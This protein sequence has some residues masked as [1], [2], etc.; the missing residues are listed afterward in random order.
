MFPSFTVFGI[1]IHCFGLI[2][3]TGL[4]IASFIMCYRIRKAGYDYN[5]T[6][7]FI[8]SLSG[9]MMVGGSILNA[10]VH[11]R[12][13]LGAQDFST[14]LNAVKS[15]CNGIVFYGGLFG[16]IIAGLIY[17]K[18][19]KLPKQLYL[20]NSALFAPLFHGVARIGCFCGGC[21]YGIESKFGFSAAHVENKLVPSLGDVTRFPVQ[22]LESACNFILAAVIFLLLKKGVLKGKLFYVYLLSYSVIRFFDEFLRG[23]DLDRGFVG[24]FSTSQFISIFVFAFAA[25][26]LFIKPHLPKKAENVNPTVAEETEK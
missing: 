1:T 7:L 17:I 26:M 21:C 13:I 9:G 2:G 15:A 14:F 16:A 10:I 3:V 23:D 12:I 25:F 5:D 4:L 11:S 19:A 22:L 6:I 20:D 24:P 18:C 8:V